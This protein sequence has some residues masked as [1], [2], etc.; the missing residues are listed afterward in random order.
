LPYGSSILLYIPITQFLSFLYDG[1]VGPIDIFSGSVRLCEGTKSVGTSAGTSATIRLSSLEAYHRYVMIPH[2]VQSDD[3]TPNPDSGAQ[4]SDSSNHES[5]IRV[6]SS[7]R[8]G[9]LRHRKP[10]ISHEDLQL[11]L[12]CHD[13]AGKI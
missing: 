5:S 6:K 4:A 3:V 2:L 8:S 13:V 12:S 10:S 11:I 7:R 9:L 1:R